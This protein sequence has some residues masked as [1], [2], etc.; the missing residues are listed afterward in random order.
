MLFDTPH[1]F[2]SFSLWSHAEWILWMIPSEF[3]LQ[4]HECSILLHI[5]LNI[6]LRESD[7]NLFPPNHFSIIIYSFLFN[8]KINL[9][10][11]IQFFNTI[12]SKHFYCL[13][14]QNRIKQ[15]T[16]LYLKSI[17]ISTPLINIFMKVDSKCLDVNKKKKIGIKKYQLKLI[18]Q[19][20]NNLS[21]DMARRRYNK[22]SV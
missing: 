4:F 22:A 11:Y 9:I 20:I 10:I 17:F 18:Y 13:L 19:V 16:I 14:H 21:L 7:R 8:L 5:Q 15:F 1:S 2:K 12:I 3:L 6:N